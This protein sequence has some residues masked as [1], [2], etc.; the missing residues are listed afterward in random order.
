MRVLIVEDE[1][2]TGH[3]LRKGLQENGSWCGETH[4]QKATYF[5]QELLC[6]PT[7][8]DFILYKYGPFSFDLRDEL[9]TL[10]ADGVFKL[11]PQPVPYGPKM[12]PT[13]QGIELQKQFPRTLQRYKKQIDFVAEKLGSKNVSEL[14][15]LA[16]ALYVT[17]ENPSDNSEEAR[18]ERIHDRKQHVSKEAAK[19]FV[20]ELDAICKESRSAAA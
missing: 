14:E 4:L 2:K 9:T 7:G 19:S 8:F 16:T 1:V 17:R 15:G 13:D 12:L 3:Y 5:L 6:V 11:E 20:K 18:A 10:C